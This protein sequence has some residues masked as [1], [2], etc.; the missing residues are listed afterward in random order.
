MTGRNRC[1]VD[2]NVWL[3]AFIASQ[4]QS[5]SA[6]AANLISRESIAINTQVVNEVCVNLIRKAA[7]DEPSVR[8]LIA[9]FYSECLV[10]PLVKAVLVTASELREA[11]S[12]SYWDSTILESALH[13]QAEV[14]YSEDLQT[15]LVVRGALRIVNPFAMK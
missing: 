8:A 13:C 6:A 7:F 11:Y 9:A 4:D 5:K 3:Y 10:V 12:L 14:L 2:T 15:G 1:F